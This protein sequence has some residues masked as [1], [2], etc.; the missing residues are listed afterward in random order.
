MPRNLTAG[1]ITEATAK[2]NRPIMLFEGEFKTNTLRLWNG[3][4]NLSWNSQTWLGNG[5]LR[6]VENAEESIQ[7]EALDL[8]VVLSGIPSSVLSLVLGDQKQSAPG[9]LY[10]GFLD[11]AG[12]VIANPYLIW[13]GGYSHAEIS[14]SHNETTV[15]LT[16][17]SRLSDMDKPREGRWTYDI[18]Q[19]LFSGD[20][21]FQYVIAASDWSGN[22]GGKKEP[23]KNKKK[24]N[25]QKGTQKR[26]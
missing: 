11:A 10:I 3:Y 20:V 6:G 5:Y 13:F 24:D 7:V 23:P 2:S 4:G 17:E 25:S 19:A 16:Y 15:R 18:Q 22:W 12:A 9:R 1:F 21:G 14:E 26:G 8:T